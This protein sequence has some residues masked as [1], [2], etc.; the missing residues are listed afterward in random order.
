MNIKVPNLIASSI[1]GGRITH[2][3][4]GGVKYGT[5]DLNTDLEAVKDGYISLSP[6]SLDLT[7]KETVDELRNIIF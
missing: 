3:W 7:H 1:K 2:H 4:I 5:G 6:L